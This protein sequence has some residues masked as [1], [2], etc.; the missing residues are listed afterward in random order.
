MGPYDISPELIALGALA[1]LAL[2]TRWVFRSPR[3]GTARPVDAADSPA[4]GLLSVVLSGVSRAEALRHRATLGESGIRS[5]M[6]RRHDATMDVLV[7]HADAD[8]A[9]TLLGS[10]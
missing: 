7:F 1:V 9:R 3:R 10:W 5:S 6:S 2:A 4:L 8:L